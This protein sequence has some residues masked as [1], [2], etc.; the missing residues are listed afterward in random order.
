MWHSFYCFGFICFSPFLGCDGGSHQLSAALWCLLKFNPEN[1][2]E[3]SNL[4]QKKKRGEK[5]K[6]GGGLFCKLQDR[7]LDVFR[8]GKVL[9]AS[10]CRGVPDL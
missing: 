7:E 9:G 8:E 3:H 1:G 5:K 10:H 6:G 2:T 4:L